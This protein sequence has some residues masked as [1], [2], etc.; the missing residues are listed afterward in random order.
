[1]IIEVTNT[2]NSTEEILSYIQFS[3]YI[4][5]NSVRSKSLIFFIHTGGSVNLRSVFK[6]AWSKK[7]IDIVV[8]ELTNE[9]QRKYDL[10]GISD[11]TS[12]VSVHQYNPF[13]DVYQTTSYSDAID[14]FQYK[15]NNLHA[16][17]VNVAV[18]EDSPNVVINKEYTGG[19]FR[20]FV[21]GWHTEYFQIIVETLNF[22]PNPVALFTDY[23]VQLKLPLKML[24][25]DYVPEAMELNNIDV[26]INLIKYKFLNFDNI[27]SLRNTSYCNTPLFY[28]SLSILV[29]QNGYLK[30]KSINLLRIFLTFTVLT[31]Y[32]I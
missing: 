17:P 11:K 31:F 7:I 10:N 2:M 20:N 1:M 19:N 5:G 9:D 25:F 30:M 28:E 27:Q 18:F 29:K 3:L 22:L 12:S 24:N 14:L 6:F 23:H 13:N 4:L 8:I 16:Y 21:Q 15:F 32:C 26:I